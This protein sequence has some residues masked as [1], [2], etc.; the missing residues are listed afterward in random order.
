MPGLASCGRCGSPLDL[1]AVAVDVHPPRASAT[2]KRLRR[3]FPRHRF[4]RARDLVSESLELTSARFRLDYRVPLPAPQVARRLIVPGWAHIH[5][6]FALRGWAFLGAYALLLVFGLLN[7]GN[8]LGAM[9]L[10]F[11]FSLHVS[12]VLDILV[13]QAT[14]TFPSM[15]T[16][17]TLVSAVLALG[18]YAPA[19]WVLLGVA[20]TRQ[21]D[22][23]APP[24]ARFDVVL[25]NRWAFTARSPRPGDV[26][27][28]QAGT[29]RILPAGALGRQV[30]E[31]IQES[32]CI[33]RVLGAP[34]DHV[35]WKDGK[36]S[37]NGAAVAWTPLVPATFPG[38]LKIIVPSDRYLILPST[39]RVAM[40][41]VPAAQWEWLGCHP[42][43]E[44]LGRVYL[45]INPL[46]RF[47][48]IR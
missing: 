29:E 19:S 4:F 41:G 45:R 28:F 20:A 16:T 34:G 27:L 8:T 7:W 31:L 48:F 12:S 11:A 3:W 42:A 47:W 22:Y 46:S 33:D 39:S 37:I 2:A 44:I 1:A 10:G 24:F 32:E 25:F 15:L 36:L 23:N 13:R 43:E 35:H 18:V 5:C 40:A 9:L 38:E 6:G 30:R 21:F 17:A 14:V 26:V